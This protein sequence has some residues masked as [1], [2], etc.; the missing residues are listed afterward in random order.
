M[1]VEN[2]MRIDK[3]IQIEVEGLSKTIT[4]YTSD[5]FIKSYAMKI[6]MVDLETDKEL[7]I[8]LV[9]KLLEWY[10]EEIVVISKNEYVANKGSH[11]KSYELLKEWNRDFT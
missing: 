5:N 7:F 6:Q 9:A 4:Q 11:Y 8:I 2:T 3:E 10:S 1:N